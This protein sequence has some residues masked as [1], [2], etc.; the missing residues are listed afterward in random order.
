MMAGAGNNV[1]IGA[2]ASQAVG[3][4]LPARLS[5]ASSAIKNK[6]AS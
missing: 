5:P 2:L 3:V 6:M 1:D 4:A